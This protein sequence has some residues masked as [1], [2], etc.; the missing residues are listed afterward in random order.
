MDKRTRIQ[1]TQ[2]AALK[3]RRGPFDMRKVIS[4]QGATSVRLVG[5]QCV[6]CIAQVGRNYLNIYNAE[7]AKI[8]GHTQ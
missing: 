8:V 4:G 3:A 5:E 1:R 7:F 6:G 2:P